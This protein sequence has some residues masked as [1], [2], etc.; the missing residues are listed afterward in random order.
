MKLYLVILFSSIF[1]YLVQ[2]Q[3]LA[4]DFLSYYLYVVQI[5]YKKMKNKYR[6]RLNKKVLEVSYEAMHRSFDETFIVS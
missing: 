6:D 2:G 3:D 5:I 1:Y 4:I